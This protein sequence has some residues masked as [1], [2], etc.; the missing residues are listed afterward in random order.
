VRC[1][2]PVGLGRTTFDLFVHAGPQIFN[3]ERLWDFARSSNLFLLRCQAPLYRRAV[4][5]P[6]YRDS[7]EQ[8][9]E[10]ALRDSLQNLDLTNLR[11]VRLIDLG[12]GDGS[13]TLPIVD[14]IVPHV[15]TFVYTP[16]DVSP[17]FLDHAA[18]MNRRHPTVAVEPQFCSFE[19]LRRSSFKLRP[20]TRFVVVIGLTFLNF[21]FPDILRILRRLTVPEDLCYVAAI[22]SKSGHSSDELLAPYSSPAHEA[23]N[24]SILRHLGFAPRDV[25]YN[26]RLSGDAIEIGFVIRR[27]PAY[28]STRGFR[29][30]DVV[31]T[32]R[33]FRYSVERYKKMLGDGFDACAH[34]SNSRHSIVVSWCTR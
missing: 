18:L 28:L 10:T 4:A 26:V 2:T 23:F 9:L 25:T 1:A 8:P 33:S 12:P 30:R 16:V 32:A 13:N 15:D 20:N 17:I 29:E 3:G 34:T 14:A 31:L 7:I 5:D 19:S 6:A 21:A 27:V 11:H 22:V 24:F